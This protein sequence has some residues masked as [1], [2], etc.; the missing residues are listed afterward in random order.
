MKICTPKSEAMALNWRT[1][2]CLL[3]VG[4]EILPQT[5]EFKYL[6][7]LLT[8]EGKMEREINRRIGAASAM[9]WALHQSIVAKRELS[10][11]AKL[12]VYRLIFV[13]TLTYGHEF[14][15]VTV[16]MKSRLK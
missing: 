10:Q 14:G 3:Q 15:V 7:F 5:E 6:G 11:T 8:S 9:M 12:S 2:D 16:R 13:P 1:V 4:E